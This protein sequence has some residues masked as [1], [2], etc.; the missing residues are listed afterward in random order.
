MFSCSLILAIISNPSIVMSYL[1]LGFFC[2][3]GAIT[4]TCCYEGWKTQLQSSIQKRKEIEQEAAKQALVSLG[5]DDPEKV[6]VRFCQCF[7]LS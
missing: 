4:V 5:I 6:C 2:F 7:I 1:F 3:V